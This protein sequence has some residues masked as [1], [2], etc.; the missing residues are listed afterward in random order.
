MN[1]EVL[2]MQGVSDVFSALPIGAILWAFLGIVFIV[3]GVY[4]AI[5]LWHWKEYSTGK[6][7]TV[8]NMFVYLGVS[9]GLL[10]LMFL[11]ASWYSLS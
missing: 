9:G 8:A 2:D 10:F 6:Y 1:T 11:S 7:T 5:M 4:S 3:Y